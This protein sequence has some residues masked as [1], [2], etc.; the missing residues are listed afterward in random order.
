M[1][2]DVLA[3]S[4]LMDSTPGI[5]SSIAGTVSDAYGGGSGLMGL[6]GGSPDPGIQAA[7][8]AQ[9]AG[10][11]GQTQAL[12]AQSGGRGTREARYEADARLPERQPA[13]A[14]RHRLHCHLLR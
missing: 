9:M 11:V 6:F 5:N 3:L 2:W 10:R 1:R 14:I 7:M 12:M 13:P 4:A 8:D